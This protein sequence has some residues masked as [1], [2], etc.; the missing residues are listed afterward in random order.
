VN[1]EVQE[2]EEHHAALM[3]VAH[4]LTEAE[5]VLLL[6]NVARQ[7]PRLQGAEVADVLDTTTDHDMFLDQTEPFFERFSD[8]VP[9]DVRL[10]AALH[11][12]IL[13]KRGLT[14]GR[15]IALLQR[16][17]LAEAPRYPEVEAG[18]RAYE[19][20]E[21]GD[22]SVTDANHLLVMARAEQGMRA[23]G[24]PEH[25]ITEFRASVRA[26]GPSCFSRNVADIAAWVTLVDR[27]TPM[28]RRAYD[29][30][31]D[32]AVILAGLADLPLSARQ[33]KAEAN[34]RSHLN[35]RAPETIKS[36]LRSYFGKAVGE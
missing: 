1:L 15:V 21:P 28:P 31:D 13:L 22:A 16:A 32:I 3:A 11:A 5:R 36:S 29:P 18:L 10:S 6:G 2:H 12:I 19:H 4:A 14:P 34:L 26:G 23:A 35:M 7:Y 9:Q 33:L 17:G 8:Q 25:V 30:T 24:I 20:E 27:Y